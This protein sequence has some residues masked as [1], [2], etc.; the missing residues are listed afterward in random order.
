M[1]TGAVRSPSPL[2]GSRKACSVFRTLMEITVDVYRA[3][4]DDPMIVKVWVDTNL[5][6]D[7]GHF[8]SVDFTSKADD[9]GIENTRQGLLAVIALLPMLELF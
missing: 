7:S 6:G 1:G 2:I 9:A 4:N 3:S 5:L 8:S